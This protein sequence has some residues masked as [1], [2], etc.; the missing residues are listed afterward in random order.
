MDAIAKS[1]DTVTIL[2]AYTESQS[3]FSAN[4]LTVV[5]AGADAI[6]ATTETTAG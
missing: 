2:D 1:V 4:I 5:A 3:N 6:I